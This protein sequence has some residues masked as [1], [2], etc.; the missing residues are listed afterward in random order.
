[1]NYLEIKSERQFKDATGFGKNDFNTLLSD[2][3][4][5]FSEEYGQSYEEYIEENVV[6]PPKLKTLG[7][8]LF[9]ILFQKKNGLLWGTLGLVFGMAGSTAHD[10][11]K[12]FSD[13][14][15]LTLEKKKMMPKRKFENVEEFES[16]VKG[17]KELI[18]DGFENEAERPQDYE[19][20]K[21][22]FSGKLGTHSDIALL[23]S[24]KKKWIYYVSM[25]YDGSN[26]DIG[27][28]KK[29]F[30]PG[31]Y[32]FIKFKVLFDLG[33]QG[34]DKLYKFKELIIGEKKKRKSK[35]NPSPKLTEEQKEWN[36]KVSRERIFVEHAIGRLKKFRILKNR[37][38]LKCDKLK[39]QIIGICAGLAN[40]QLAIKG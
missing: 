1:M 15:E 6:N 13:L 35:K 40:Y 38:R 8:A 33:F 16:H 29:E 2:F 4:N 27:I 3:E 10:K 21:V 19:N 17:A 36:K 30:L 23:L 11:F 31:L 7:E 12:V 18:F 20:Q 5:T 32:W 37:C 9:F 22:K 28:L 24:D 25:L 34:V 39:N 26:V 14:L